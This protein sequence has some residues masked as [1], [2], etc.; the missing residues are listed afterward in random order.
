MFRSDLVVER[1]DVEEICSVL[2]FYSWALAE[3]CVL[4]SNKELSVDV[5]DV[6]DVNKD[7]GDAGEAVI[8]ASD[9]TSAEVAGEEVEEEG[10]EGR[11]GG[12]VR[13]E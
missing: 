5:D 10:G 8:A 12:G 11:E 6:V 4:Q 13:H 1:P 2:V 7:E 3:T 9:D